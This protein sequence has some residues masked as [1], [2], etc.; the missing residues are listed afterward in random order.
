MK[1]LKFNPKAP[2]KNTSTFQTLIWLTIV[3]GIFLWLNFCI[4]GADKDFVIIQ[5]DAS[6][7]DLK[8]RSLKALPTP[9]PQ[10]AVAVTNS[11]PTSLPQ[12]AVAVTNS[13]PPSL[14]QTAVIISSSWS[15]KHPSLEKIEAI[16]QSIRE[17]IIGLNNDTTPIFITANEIPAEEQWKYDMKTDT[18]NEYVKRLHLNYDLPESNIHI[19]ASAEGVGGNIWKALRLMKEKH[20]SL[21]YLYHVRHDFKFSRP[22]DHVAL[23][24]TMKAHNSNVTSSG[25][26]INYILFP[27]TDWTS[28][29]RQ[30]EDKIAIQSTTNSATTAATTDASSSTTTV[31]CKFCHYS[32]SSHLVEFDWYYHQIDSLGYR[33]RTPESAM[34]SHVKRKGKCKNYGLHLYIDE[35][36]FTM[37]KQ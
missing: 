12:T 31:L 5:H 20:P 30:G 4:F 17:N 21:E 10:T 6:E 18:L 29:C 1:E 37:S 14:P 3:L 16:I 26:K 27:Y 11:P 8:V 28:S 7:M 32:D 19:I 35:N 15:P 2:K 22:I 9:L 24:E 36:G 34:E 23:L 13:P 25:D 33:K